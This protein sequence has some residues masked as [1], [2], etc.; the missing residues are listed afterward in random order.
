MSD[1]DA[2]TTN[3]PDLM[4]KMHELRDAYMDTW[5]KYLVEEVK[6]ESYAQASGTALKNFLNATAPF[7]EPA[8]QAMLRTLQQLNIPTSADFA[9]LAGRVTNIEMQLDNMDATLDR[10]EKLL[11]AAQPARTA[12]A[13]IP[14]KSVSQPAPVKQTSRKPAEARAVVQEPVARK[15]RSKPAVRGSAIARATAVKAAGRKSR[16]GTK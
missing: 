6:S 4:E 9:G 13:A 10:I 2:K 1:A 11:T 8:E 3:Q 5:S 7:K 15:N 16:K 14:A 12:E